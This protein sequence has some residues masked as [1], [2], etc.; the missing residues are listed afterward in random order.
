V[1]FAQETERPSGP[2]S[3]PISC[4]GGRGRYFYPD[5]QNQSHQNRFTRGWADSAVTRIK[6]RG[7]ETRNRMYGLVLSNALL[8]GMQRRQT[9]NENAYG[10]MIRAI[11]VEERRRGELLT[12]TANSAAARLAVPGL[13]SLLSTSAE[14]A[15]AD[16]RL[17]IWNAVAPLIKRQPPVGDE[18]VIFLFVT[19]GL[20]LIWSQ[21]RDSLREQIR[22]ARRRR[23]AIQH[24]GS[25]LDHFGALPTYRD[26]ER[27]MMLDYVFRSPDVM[28]ESKE[29]LKLLRT[30]EDT[31]EE[32]ARRL[33]VSQATI[34]R[35]NQ[36][37]LEQARAVLCAPGSH[38]KSTKI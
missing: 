1:G 22:T 29:L 24:F 31:Q 4:R 23:E 8:I 20:N 33:G 2:P 13:T 6:R 21:T 3:R 9:R 11:I 14:D 37:A 5:R 19:G 30:E 38:P 36:I 32:F 15:R 34:S 17:H 12:A 18:D 28:T 35:R 27:E 10:R 16:A 7:G 25:D 26:S